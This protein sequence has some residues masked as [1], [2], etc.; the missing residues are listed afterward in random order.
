MSRFSN[1]TEAE[2]HFREILGMTERKEGGS[3]YVNMGEYSN[4][5]TKKSENPTKILCLDLAPFSRSVQFLLLSFA[6]FFFYLIYGYLQE[7][8]FRL[9]EFRP[10]G[11]YLTLV[12]FAC[13]TG[14]GCI[15][16]ASTGET[17]RRI[18]LTKYFLLAFLTVATMGLSNTSV[19]YLNYPTQVIF[20]CCKLIPVLIGGMFIQGKRYS[21]LDITAVLLMVVGL[22]L[23]TLAD[24]SVSPSFNTY[25]VILISLALCADG[26]IGNFQEKF[27]KQYSAGN[28]EMVFYSYSIGFVYIL[29]GIII[30]GDLFPA[31]KVCQKYPMETYGYAVIFSL[32]GYLGVNVVLTLVRTFGALMAVTVTTCRKAVT[33]VLSFLFFT[34]PFTYQYVW[35]GLIVV[36][37]IYLN[38]Y[39]KNKISW[40]ATIS[41]YYYKL[42]QRLGIE[43]K[44]PIESV[45]ATIV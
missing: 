6:T 43:R 9:E 7:L 12:Q 38:V 39:S 23:F 20:K 21:I 24:N 28:S 32:S 44:Y 26:G 29:F 35:S 1:Q 34:K 42:R 17:T 33:I 13:Y 36:A 11:W 37:G 5:P 27:L 31:F 8:I 41:N 14:F 22:I 25:G 40:D 18:P 19:G 30:S 4:A 16:M 15:E 45:A 2:R 3:T 10:Y